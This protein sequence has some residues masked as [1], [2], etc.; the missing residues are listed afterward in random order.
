[1][2][3]L[4]AEGFAKRIAEAADKI[5]EVGKRWEHCTDNFS[6]DMKS[7]SSQLHSI[8]R[9]FEGVRGLGSVAETERP[10]IRRVGSDVFREARKTGGNCGKLLQE[11]HE[12]LVALVSDLG[13]TG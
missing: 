4:R 11:A 1:M 6:R 8:R 12:I 5:W 2:S 7:L 9:E 13:K 3:D 10:K